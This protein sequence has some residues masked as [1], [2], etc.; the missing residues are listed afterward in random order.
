MTA[1]PSPNYTLCTTYASTAVAASTL[2][3]SSVLI[4]DCEAR[5]IGRSTGVLSI[6][7]ISDVDAKTIFLIDALALPN[8]SH[9]AFKPLFRLLR[10]E[11]VTK[12]VWDGRA[13]AVELRETYGVELRG[14]LDLQL[15]EVGSR[16]PGAER[17]RLLHCFKTLKESIKRN[18][19]TWDQ[20][21]Q[22]SCR[23]CASQDIEHNP[24]M[25]LK[26]PLPE[27]LLRYAAHDL[28]LIGQLYVNFQRAG[29]INKRNV[30][31]L[32]AQSERYLRTFRTRA[33]KD[34]FDQRGLGPF[35]PLHVLEKPFAKARCFECAGC[36]QLLILHW[37]ST[38]TRDGGRAPKQRTR[39]TYCKLCVALAKKKSEKFKG[40]WVAV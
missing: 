29:W 13:D 8:A 33:I 15:A 10:S 35:M 18:P 4:L 2:S 5:D 28:E 14:V 39:C 30:P 19:P 7:S 40:K 12:L 16:K 1:R 31:Q 21:Y 11:A 20:G 22:R 9:P 17:Q 26:R 38:G 27:M 37:F 24:D 3:H 6:V 32:K 25:W 36:K 23:R 34:L